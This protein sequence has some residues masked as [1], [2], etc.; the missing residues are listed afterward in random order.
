MILFN[1]EDADAYEV[2][3]Q[4]SVDVVYVGSASKRLQNLL[5]LTDELL[6]TYYD[7]AQLKA[8]LKAHGLTTQ[9]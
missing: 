3:L 9:P 4:E 5:E 7:E 6:I 8:I 1:E 2:F